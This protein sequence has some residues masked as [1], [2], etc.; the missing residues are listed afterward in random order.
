LVLDK[1]AFFPQSGGQ[2]SD[3]GTIN[4]ANVLDVQKVGNVI[5]HTLDVPIKENEYVVGKI[6]GD[7]RFAI[8]KN[9]SATHVINGVARRLLGE[10]IWQSGSE[11]TPDKA[12]LD[13]THFAS[14]TREELKEMERLANEV[15]AADLPVKKTIYK[16]DVAEQKFG[17]RLYQGGAVPG[18]ELRVVEIPGFDVEACGGTHVKRTGEIGFIK[19]LGSKRIQD[20]IIRLEFVAGL[21]AL[22]EIQKDEDMISKACEIFSIP[23][24]HLVKTCERF[25]KEWKDQRKQIDSIKQKKN[26]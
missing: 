20:G 4:N 14:L 5:L 22:E 9:H 23:K 6:D 8:M 21:K 17:F 24:E 10:H 25:F 13:I 7:R 3:I 1:T 26:G 2:V 15:V 11:V 19:I 18:A 12:R 16:K